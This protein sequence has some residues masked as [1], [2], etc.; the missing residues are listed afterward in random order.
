M[1]SGTSP[2]ER[3]SPGRSAVRTWSWPVVRIKASRQSSSRSRRDANAAGRRE[4]RPSGTAAGAGPRGEGQGGDDR[5]IVAPALGTV[6]GTMVLSGD[7]D[8]GERWL[9]RAWEV[10]E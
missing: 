9:R 7:F 2:R 8:E 10:A 3:R 6:G 5:R 1:P 4:P